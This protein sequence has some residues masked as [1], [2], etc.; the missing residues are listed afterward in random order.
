VQPSPIYALHGKPP[1]EFAEHENV[2]KFWG[3]LGWTLV[4]TD[5]ID[6]DGYRMGVACVPGREATRL[7]MPWRPRKRPAHILQLF[8][9][10]TYPSGKLR[11]D[12]RARLAFANGE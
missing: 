1:C 8:R 11:H 4:A 5:V 9:P 3:R 7:N 2:Q 6:A 10:L 12:L